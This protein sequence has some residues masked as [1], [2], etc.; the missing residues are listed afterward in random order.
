MLSEGSKA[1]TIIVKVNDSGDV[2]S[3]FGGPGS[4]VFDKQGPP[5]FRTT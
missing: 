1:G 2:A 3:M 4:L 5:G